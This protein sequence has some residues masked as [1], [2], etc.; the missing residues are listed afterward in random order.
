MTRCVIILL[1]LLSLCEI[2]GA[3]VVTTKGRDFWVAF[4]PN[5]PSGTDWD[6]TLILSADVATTGEVS[7]SGSMWS[8]SFSV[9]PGVPTNITVPDNCVLSVSEQPSWGA[10]HVTTQDDV[11]LYASNYI[12]GSYDN[13]NV[14]PTN[15]LRSD[16][17]L[18]SFG[19]TYLENEFCI[20]APEDSTVVHIDMPVASTDSIVPGTVHTVELQQGEAY[21][22]KSRMDISGT[23]VWT[24]ECKPVAVF[25]GNVCAKVPSNCAFCDHLFE[26]AVPI[27]Y[28]GRKFGVTPTM[29]RTFDLL[30]VTALKDSTLVSLGGTAF[31]LDARQSMTVRID[32]LAVY[33]ESSKPLSAYLYLTGSYCGGAHGDPSVSV[34]HPIE[35]QL[36]SIAF[37][38]FNTSII[39]SHF[40]NI[41]T[42]AGYAD[43]IFLDGRRIH[44]SRFYPLTGNSRYVYAREEVSHGSHTLFSQNGGFVAH[45]Y[46]LGLE[47]SYSYS[48]GG[49][50][51]LINP[52]LFLNNVPF[53]G[54]NSTNNV[55]CEG[56]SLYFSAEVL[57]DTNTAISWNF[58]D[59]DSASG[60]AVSHAYRQP[61][62]YTVKVKLAHS[63]SCRYVVRYADS[64]RVHIKGHPESYTDTVVCDTNC[65][66]N[67]YHYYATGT[68]SLSF[69][70]GGVCDS[71]AWLNISDMHL[72]PQPSI[73]AEFNCAEMLFRLSAVGEG[74]YLQWFSV[75][76]NPDIRGH[77]NDN[78]LVVEPDILRT[79]HLYMAYSN[80][81]LCGTEVSRVV[82]HVN[83]VEALPSAKPQ[84]VPLNNT[85][86]LLTDNSQNI[87]SRTW[88][89]LGSPIGNRSSI[90][91]SYPIDRDSVDIS[92]EVTDIYG[93]SDTAQLTLSLIRDG[94]YIPNIIT[95]ANGQNGCFQVQGYSIMD[96]EVLI[97]SRQGQQLWH[98]DNIND[99]WDATYEGRDLPSGTYVYTIRYR[100]SQAP[101]VWLHK[102]GTVTVIR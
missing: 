93:C 48:V 56:D 95:P 98:T 49:A 27:S 46:G 75:P 21:L 96:G 1:L 19:Q 50:L 61:G 70:T 77:Q 51:D 9:T 36:S 35:Q 24:D 78:P 60:S 67:G 55:F 2:G 58:G 80:D 14:F 82:P 100:Y 12:A 23:V 89:A 85:T 28:W 81:S 54:C 39:D 18:Q 99:C 57:D 42:A 41:V 65:F 26:Q 37:A 94:I 45:I 62:D 59:G 90:E 88:Y 84:R 15:T 86:V 13:T 32:S 63:D 69:P 30:K 72:P 11:S 31:V 66:W 33:I 10:V 25:V 34:L 47:E 71:I 6:L 20:I 53:I 68:F 7:V 29:S 102:T 22:V 101:N 91:Y 76:F 92:L 3:Q 40:V 73:E 4:M 97:F 83:A 79:Y 87:I 38:T 43:N 16:Y 17:L 44:R 64:V 5:L 8:Q 52:H 74:D